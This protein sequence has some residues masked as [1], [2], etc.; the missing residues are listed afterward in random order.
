M[1]KRQVQA[2][3]VEDRYLLLLQGLKNTLIITF[4]ALMLGLA[5]GLLVAIVK[6]A[7]AN[8]KKFKPLS[9]LADI[10]LTVIRGTPVVVQ[11]IIKMCIRDRICTGQKTK[12]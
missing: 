6:V 10:Y 5:I 11:L 3:I 8:N 9:W 4:F 1:Y 12:G 7:G 2:L